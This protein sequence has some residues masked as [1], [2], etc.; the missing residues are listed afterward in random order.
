MKLP[1]V[2]AG[3][4]RERGTQIVWLLSIQE[5]SENDAHSSSA[6]VS[7]GN[8]DENLSW[9]RWVSSPSFKKIMRKAG[10]H[11]EQEHCGR[12]RPRSY[13]DTREL[14]WMLGVPWGGPAEAHRRSG[15]PSLNSFPVPFADKLRH[16]L[17]QGMTNR[18]NAQEG[19][20]VGMHADAGLCVTTSFLWCCSWKEKNFCPGEHLCNW[21][22]GKSLQMGMFNIISPIHQQMVAERAPF[23]SKALRPQQLYFLLITSIWKTAVFCS[24]CPSWG[25]LQQQHY[26]AL[27]KHC[28]QLEHDSTTWGKDFR[29][30]VFHIVQELCSVK[31]I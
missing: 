1:R 8:T 4:E 24:I 23:L 20:W 27:G 11:V 25:S 29:V 12:K 10:R 3:W 22:L 16:R 2:R 17:S 14:C 26:R 18:P 19:F 21:D 9:N 13:R 31:I 15:S 6:T 7:Y 28:V 30:L 5:W